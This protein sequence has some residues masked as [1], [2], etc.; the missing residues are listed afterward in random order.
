MRSP[1]RTHFSSS[2]PRGAISYHSARGW[3]LIIGI[4]LLMLTGFAQIP[5]RPAASTISPTSAEITKAILSDTSIDGP[6]L[7]TS[8]TGT[9]RSVLAYTGTDAAHHLYVMTSGIGT[10]YV[11]RVML[12]E[13]SPVGPAVTR[14]P[15]GKV[16]VAWIGTDAS[17][18]LNVLYDVYG[19]RAKLTLWGDNSYQRPALVAVN[20][21][22]LLLSW[23]GTN[24]GRSLNV[25]VI[26]TGSA[27]TTG[28]KT[29][30]WSYSSKSGPGLAFEPTRSEYILSWSATSPANRVAFSRSSDGISW[31]APTMIAEWT[32]E[33]PSMVGIVGGYYN[34]PPN[35]LAWTGIDAP[36][37]LNVQYTRAFPSWADPATTKVTLN[38]MALGA[39]TLG[40][41]G[42]PGLMLIAWTGTDPAHHVN[43][44]VLTTMSPSPTSLP[45]VNPV[46]PKIISQGSS[47]RK[48]VALTFDEDEGV[49]NPASLLSTLESKGVTSTW[50]MTA[51]W[52]QDHPDLVTRAKGDG[53]TIANHTV[54]HPN[55]T[56]PARTDIFVCYQLGLANQIISDRAGITG[57]RP[58]FRPPYGNQNTQ[59]VNSA[60]GIGY[61]TVLW[62]I[63]PRDWDD[64][65][66]ADAIY[67][68]VTSQL[69]PGKI[70]LMHGGSLH[71]PEALPRVIDYIKSQGYAIVS[72]DRL[73]AP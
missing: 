19:T 5:A 9:V 10:L 13:L 11:N 2:A 65:T 59:V 1:I 15:N 29:I 27:L 52:A 42:G 26:K 23:T 63:D 57:T 22:T 48:E 67:S 58:Y 18:T 45:G 64:A 71:E 14:T 55:L 61:V 44:A 3:L 70:I 33:T 32:Y 72:L 12:D 51:R 36:R 6:A 62:S 53:I 17:N 21:S 34:M 69:G 54:D 30:L 43:V 7:W 37:S 49:G 4:A 46:T 38:E 73:L 56:S 50:F 68:Q 47:G 66:T 60:A 16:A 40:F 24:S 25:L 41:I 8:Y 39:P 28:A 35:E 20:D 31:S